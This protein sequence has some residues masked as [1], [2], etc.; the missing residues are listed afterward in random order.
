MSTGPDK[1][2]KD[3]PIANGK[4]QSPIDLKNDVE[5]EKEL[6]A[7]PL[8]WSYVPANNVNVENTGA[9]WKVNVQSNK[10]SSMLSFIYIKMNSKMYFLIMFNATLILTL[11]H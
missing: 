1:W 5:S 8:T 7:K 10:E 2:H 3:F 11:V 9:S 4:R 6:N